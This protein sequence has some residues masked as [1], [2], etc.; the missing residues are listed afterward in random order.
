MMY[1]VLYD[2]YMIQYA[3]MTSVGEY[4]SAWVKSGWT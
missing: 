1:G 3:D 2:M 4:R